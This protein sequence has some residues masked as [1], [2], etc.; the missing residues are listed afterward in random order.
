[1]TDERQAAA[2]ATSPAKNPPSTRK[3]SLHRIRTPEG[4]DLDLRELVLGRY[5]RREGFS[6]HPFEQDGFTGMVI[7]GTI[8]RGQADWC[9]VLGNLTGVTVQEEN[10]SA[11]GVLFVRTDR[12]VYALTYGVGHHMIDPFRLDPDFGLEFATRCLDEDGVL[13]VR[14]QIMDARGRSDEN[15]TTR[16]QPIESFGIE[17]VGAIITKITGMVSKVPFTYLRD[18][19][20][21]AV[22][23]ACRD[24]SIQ[25]PLATTAA[26]FLDDL[27]EIENVCSQPDPLP[28]L[29]FIDRIR[30]LRGKSAIVQ[31]LGD[32]LE[33]LLADPMHPRLALGVPSEC[34]DDFASAQTFQVTKGS[35]NL[36]TVQE[37]N[38]E[39]LLEFVHTLPAG[40]R[41]GALK[42][43]RVQMFGDTDCDDPVSARTSGH[44]WLTA[45]VS[46]SAGRYF[47]HQGS[48]YEIGAEYLQSIEEE[49]R[50]L[51][52]RS[53]S[54]T[55]PPWPEHFKG[56]DA[57]A[58]YNSQAAEHPGYTLFDKKT[59]V[60]KKFRGGGL[61]ICD[62]LGPENQL[63]HVKQSKDKT[64][65]LNHLFAQ[66]T[67]AVEVLRSDVQVRTKFLEALAAH[68]PSHPVTQ[69][70]G[71]LTLV[72]AI[73]LKDGEAISVDSLFAFAQI[74]LLQAVHQLRA[75]NA[76][77]EIVT[78]HR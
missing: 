42:N 28:E 34:L 2:P 44:R 10:R 20:R 13:L 61:E 12:A 72:Y 45:D 8:S 11:A 3:S 23:V 75:M 38:L 70:L 47:Y 4:L 31:R 74:S 22:R 15:A 57:E 18:G 33:R 54:V 52:R 26:E 48:W 37:L 25:L 73:L 27:R 66:G 64:A 51:F 36:H 19:K 32:E 14:R 78:I 77:V 53:A 17:R 24:S 16:G 56:K 50:D 58:R 46:V 68:D 9:Q 1:M 63:I 60:T 30:S 40:S 29:G 43:V 59:V 49:L 41:I 67:V 21:R 39:A 62:I 55:L 69:E 5:L 6:L 65:P 76:K 7:S 35:S 71:S